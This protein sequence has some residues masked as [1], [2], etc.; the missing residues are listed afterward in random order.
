MDRDGKIIIPVV[1]GRSIDYIA[2]TDPRTDDVAIET[3]LD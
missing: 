2:S 1:V 3:L